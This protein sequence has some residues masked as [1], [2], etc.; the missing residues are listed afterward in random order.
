MLLTYSSP[1]VAD[2]GH[3]SLCC[4]FPPG[5]FLSRNVPSGKAHVPGA[6][7]R[8]TGSRV[9]WAD[10]ADRSAKRTV[11]T[12]NPAQSATLQ[13]SCPGAM[14]RQTARAIDAI[15]TQRT[16]SCRKESHRSRAPSY[17]HSKTAVTAAIFVVDDVKLIEGGLVTRR[18][19]CRYWTQRGLISFHLRPAPGQVIA[20]PRRPYRP[21][22]S[23]EPCR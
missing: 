16:V 20:D 15:I 23:Q 6:V 5:M 1:F 10:H 2:R 18:R 13:S 12:T 9:R 22:G 11:P 19:P 7:T 14:S 3:F 21:G 4:S 8:Q 17:V